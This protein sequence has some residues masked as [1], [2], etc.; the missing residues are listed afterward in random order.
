M[1]VSLTN[2]SASARYTAVKIICAVVQDNKSLTD[3]LHLCE[4]LE[5]RDQAFC[6]ELCYG[7]LR[8]LYRL[9]AVLAILLKKPFKPK[10]IDIHVLALTGLYQIIYLNTPDHAAVS[11]TVKACIKS[12]KTWAKGLLNAV[13]RRF[14]RE[15]QQIET[16]VDASIEQQYAHPH[17]LV[18][19]FQQDWQESLVDILAANNQRPPMSIRVNT[20]ATNRTDYLMELNKHEI[21]ATPHPYNQIGLTLEHAVSVDRL[22]SFWQ[23]A[24]S[25]QDSAA[26]LAAQLLDIKEGQHI[27]DVCAAPGGKTAHILESAPN[28]VSLVAIDIDEQRNLRVADNLKRLKLQA[29]VLTADGL[30][31]STWF[32]NKPFQR[33]LIDAP[34]SAT[35]VIRRHPDIK[36]LRRPSDIAKL[37]ELQQQLLKSIWPLLDKNGV[38]LYATCS[39]LASENSKQIE[40]FLKQQHD[41]KE[42]PI[43]ADWGHPCDFGRQILPG[44]D[45]MDG[46]Y[47]ARLTKS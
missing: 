30:E 33:I 24:S 12:K 6:K 3:A 16:T 21:D 44:E 22:P 29:N 2:N 27:L 10:D 7:T 8:W 37:V 9:E 43:Q 25:V 34:C 35:G 42:L 38:L 17:W 47:Y 39:I 45:N 28:N 41:A 40:L 31:T 19:Q 36:I 46:F 5:I 13:L 4:H 1:Q 11:E 20:R 23:G 15:Q 14:L 18:E 32:D 26:Q